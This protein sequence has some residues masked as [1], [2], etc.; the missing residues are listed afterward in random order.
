MQI[1]ISLEVFRNLVQSLNEA[2]ESRKLKATGQKQTQDFLFNFSNEG[3]YSHLTTLYSPLKNTSV[4]GAGV[5][6]LYIVPLNCIGHKMSLSFFISHIINT[7]DHFTLYKCSSSFP[8]PLGM[9]EAHVIQVHRQVRELLSTEPLSVT[10][11]LLINSNLLTSTSQW[12]EITKAF[13][14]ILLPQLNYTSYC[15]CMPSI[16]QAICEHE[17]LIT[18]NTILHVR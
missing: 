17:C 10:L 1:C 14:N 5:F 8:W 2:L 12:P 9:S 3:F 13:L 18:R 11:I 16:L 15:F 6:T 4:L 7:L